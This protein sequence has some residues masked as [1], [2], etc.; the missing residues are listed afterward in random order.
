M[1]ITGGC[2]WKDDSGKTHYQRN[3]K[4]YLDKVKTRKRLLINL[5]ETYKSGKRCVDCNCVP[6]YTCVL[7][8]DHLP[9]YTKIMEVS[10]MV[11]RGQS[12]ESILKEIQKCEL[13][14]A[15]CHR[16]RTWNRTH[17]SVAQLDRAPVF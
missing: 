6:N 10:V 12:W 11:R 7:D 17:G 13:V 9:K 2:Q 14:C 1:K 16:I 15:N 3:K 5:I 4:Y 8:F